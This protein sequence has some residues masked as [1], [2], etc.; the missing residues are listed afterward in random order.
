M[1]ELFDGRDWWEFAC[2]A[3]IFVGLGLLIG[4][5]M[6]NNNYQSQ[7]F[8][9]QPMTG[10]DLLQ[11]QQI[12]YQNNYD[13]CNTCLSMCFQVYN[14]SRQFGRAVNAMELGILK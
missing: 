3:A 10:Y 1:F 14:R 13:E 9:A 7:T 8:Q 12:T 6:V 4:A 11:L 5:L 2:W